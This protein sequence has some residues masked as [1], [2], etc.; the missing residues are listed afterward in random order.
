MVQCLL[1]NVKQWGEAICMAMM[2]YNHTPSIRVSP[3]KLY[4]SDKPNLMHVHQFSVP[5]CVLVPLGLWG[6]LDD[7]TRPAI[8]L[9]PAHIFQIGLISRTGMPMRSWWLYHHAPTQQH[10]HSHMLDQSSTQWGQYLLTQST[11]SRS[12]TTRMTSHPHHHTRSVCPPLSPLPPAFFSC[13]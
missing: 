3:Y 9:R 12:T 10:G 13:L 2:L 4:Y 11:R 6:K 8:Y 1:I 7:Q 5:V